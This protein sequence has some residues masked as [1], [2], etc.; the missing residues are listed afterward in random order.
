MAKRESLQR[1]RRV[2]AWLEAE[3]SF[4]DGRSVGGQR[5]FFVFNGSGG[6]IRDVA[7]FKGDRQVEGLSVIPPAEHPQEIRVE[8]IVPP[9]FQ[10][11]HV[12]LAIH[13]TDAEGLRWHASDRG[14]LEQVPVIAGGS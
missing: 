9:H 11:A 7:I 6:P 4:E 3:T 8:T 13:F 2:V 10:Y 5:R 14:L 1:A 12:V